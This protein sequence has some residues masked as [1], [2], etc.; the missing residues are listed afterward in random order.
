MQKRHI[1]SFVKKFHGVLTKILPLFPWK[2]VHSTVNSTLQHHFLKGSPASL[3][4]HKQWLRF[5]VLDC[6]TDQLDCWPTLFSS[7]ENNYPMTKRKS[8]LLYSI[9]S[10]KAEIRQDFFQSQSLISIIFDPV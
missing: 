7:C 5:S 2:L 6:P 1:E 4:L 3:V 8:L 10:T 9:K